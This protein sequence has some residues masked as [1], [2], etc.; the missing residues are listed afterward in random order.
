MMLLPVM[1]ALFD[2]LVKFQIFLKEK[3]VINNW[4]WNRTIQ[5]NY[6][7]VL[8]LSYTEKEFTFKKVFV[9]YKDITIKNM[10]YF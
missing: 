10:L 3:K 7:Q 4:V 1:A 9:Y 8:S 6:Q 5:M 2:D